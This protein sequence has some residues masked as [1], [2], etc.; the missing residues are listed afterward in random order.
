MK[1]AKN[2]KRLLLAV[3]L[4][5]FLLLGSTLQSTPLPPTEQTVLLTG[6]GP[7]LNITNNPTQSIAEQLNNTQLNNAS[8]IS[9]ILPVSFEQSIQ[10]MKEAIQQFEP[11]LII[12]LGLEDKSSSI[13]LEL[14]GTN[15]KRTQLANGRWSIPHFILLGK[16]LFYTSTL[17]LLEIKSNLLDNTI[18]TKL[19]LGAGTYVC[20]SLFYQ[21]QHYLHTT[22]QEIPMGFIHL[23]QQQ[24]ID[25]N[26]LPLDQ[27]SQAVQHII[28]T[29]LTN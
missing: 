23:P 3:L 24:S 13:H 14:I 8:I 12:S 27:M 10:T 29:S 22:N 21:T 6:F 17:P 26:G 25:P 2:L 7:F 18:P 20:N 1:K 11:D 5:C 15:L 9:I 19:S 4:L 28:T 16:R